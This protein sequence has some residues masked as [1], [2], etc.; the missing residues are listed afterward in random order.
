MS[1]AE[2]EHG[3]AVIWTLVSPNAGF[4]IAV[5]GTGTSR[6]VT[7]T[8]GSSGYFLVKLWLCDSATVPGTQS[9]FPS[10][11]EDRVQWELVTN[12]SGVLT[13]VITHTGA[14]RTWYMAAAVGGRIAVSAALAFT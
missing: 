13:K 2:S 6:T 12:S 8:M 4:T 1:C 5:S 3:L 9:A 14:D 7:I 10:S 11:G